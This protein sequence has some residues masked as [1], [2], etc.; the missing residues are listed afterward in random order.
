MK[1][2]LIAPPYPLEEAPSPPL[3]LCYVAAACE[4]AGAE[5]L[6]LD[7]IVSRYTPEKLRAALDAFAPDVVGATAV[8]MNFPDAVAIIREA[9]AHRPAIVTMMGGPHVSFDVDN[10]LRR[11]P[12]LDLI[13]IGEGEATLAEL[14]PALKT[15]RRWPD[16]AGIAFR[17]G[18][19]VVR[20]PERPLIDDLNRLPLPARHLLPMSRYQA[21][22]F[23][24]SIITS[25]GCPNRCIFCLGRRM[26][27]SKP[28]FRDPRRV[29]DEIAHLLTYGISRIN[30]AD[31][32]FTADK[33]RVQALCAEI[34]RRGVRFDWS[35]FARVNTVDPA[36]LQAMRAAG[37]D[38][39]S[40][41]IESGD[42]EI[43]R[44]VRKGITLDQARRAVTWSRAAGLRVHASFMCGLPGESPETLAR[45]HRFAE[46][47]G[48]EYGFHFLSP[49]PGT[50]VRE[51]I[52]EYDLEILTDDWRQYDANQAIVRTSRLSPEEM[53]RFVAEVYH[54]QQ[55]KTDPMEAR[56]LQ[57]DCSD[58]E[59]LMFE[60]LYRMRLVYRLL[61]ED[62]IEGAR[63]P[64]GAD[65][66][67]PTTALVTHI[68][69]TTRMDTPL[70]DRTIK[71][72]VERGYLRWETHG[73]ESCWFWTYNNRLP[74]PPP[75]RAT[76]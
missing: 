18:D 35:A 10:T 69:R 36:T 20:T 61:A 21:L 31:D 54:R 74:H 44:R 9:K 68:A 40:F 7:F 73:E 38:S 17:R 48:I 1:I 24:A 5:V 11:H 59:Y 62:M 23:P 32:L 71:A 42:P 14:I 12:E 72:L 29:V 37:C 55:E 64:A 30:I 45:S 49:F 66:P 19:A 46:E 2:A 13:V 57:G 76:G 22:G 4:A 58:Q 27:G 70:V 28:R 6:L 34:T 52:A 67:D 33:R 41:G 43:L 25:R 53:D 47:L 50:R 3:G 51:E 16:I 15:P 75:G 65:G 39:I 56:Y 26:V 63:L 8:T 60:G